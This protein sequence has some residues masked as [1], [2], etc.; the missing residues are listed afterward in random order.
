MQMC[1]FPPNKA[2]VKRATYSLVQN[3]GFSGIDADKFECTSYMMWMCTETSTDQA[4][5]E[6]APKDTVDCGLGRTLKDMK[7]DGQTVNFN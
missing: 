5:P 7:A 2:Q 1:G 4:E 6:I 3:C